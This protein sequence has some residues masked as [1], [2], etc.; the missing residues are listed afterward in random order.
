MQQLA[1]KKRWLELNLHFAFNLLPSDNVLHMEADWVCTSLLYR[2]DLTPTAS[3]QAVAPPHCEA[4]DCI[5][6]DFQPFGN[7]IKKD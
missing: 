2:Y 7:G 6:I 3:R 5:L 1:K 4:T